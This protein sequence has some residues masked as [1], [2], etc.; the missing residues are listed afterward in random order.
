M[1]QVEAGAMLK[2][3]IMGNVKDVAQFSTGLDALIKAG[4][5]VSSSQVGESIQDGGHSNEARQR[6]GD[7]QKR[8]WAEAEKYAKKHGITTN[9]ARHKLAELKRQ[10]V[11]A[12]KTSARK[13]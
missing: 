9:E 11:G 7:A 13:K 3:K 2:F 6:Q 12:A 10:K 4:L 1:N 8:Y 5:E